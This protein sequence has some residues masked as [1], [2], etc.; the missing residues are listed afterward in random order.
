MP[1]LQASSW[2][3][4]CSEFVLSPGTGAWPWLPDAHSIWHDLPPLCPQWSQ[5]LLLCLPLNQ[6]CLCRESIGKVL[7]SYLPKGIEC[8][9]P[10]CDCSSSGHAAPNYAT[11]VYWLFEAITTE[12]QRTQGELFCELWR[13][14]LLPKTSIVID[15]LTGSFI[16]QGELTHHRK[17]KSGYHTR[18]NLLFFWRSIL[19]WKSVLSPERF[20]SLLIFLY[21]DSIYIN[22]RPSREVTQFFPWVSSMYTW[23]KLVN[24]L[25]YFSL[26]I[27]PFITGV[28]AKSSEG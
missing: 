24:E 5:L 22:S 19:P 7:A 6:Q 25:V 17:T 1:L 26:A 10:E 18:T 12:N 9:T 14:S 11:L 8:A 15:L 27:L 2:Y 13:Q 20:I 23:H 16:N 4:C 3:S 28:L 21:L